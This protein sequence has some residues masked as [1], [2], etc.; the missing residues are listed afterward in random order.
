MPSVSVVVPAAGL[1]TRMGAG[2]RKPYIEIEGQPILF[3]TLSQF[4]GLDEVEEI[5]LVV[6]PDDVSDI[7]DK[8]GDLFAQ[9]KVKT[10]C[11][12]GHER[13]HSVF[14]GLRKTSP[15]CDVV[16]IQDAVR[17]MVSRELIRQTIAAVE[18]H[19]AAIVAA[20]V[21]ETVKEVDEEGRIVA[22]RPRAR[23]WLAQT[24]Q[25]FRRELILKAY[26]EVIR[27]GLDIT[28]DAEVVEAIGGSV[29]VVPGGYDNLK[30]TTPEDLAI[31]EAL[32]GTRGP[33]R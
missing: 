25:G 3:H 33:R 17:P 6:H 14:N 8:H 10:V 19:G 11:A 26:E 1:G 9:L 31:A 15:Q 18:Q 16:L 7:K 30:I 20:R 5:V 29:Y 2:P 32:M 4:A 12:G 21:K 13:Q 22:T 27:R 23:L 28:D 24:P